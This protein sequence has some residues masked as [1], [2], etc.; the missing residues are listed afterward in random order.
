M[1]VNPNQEIRNILVELEIVDQD[2]RVPKQIVLGKAAG[3]A[4]A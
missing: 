2:P 1:L 3:I 4:N